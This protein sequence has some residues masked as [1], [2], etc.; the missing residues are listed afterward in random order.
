MK[1][2]AAAMAGMAVVD[3]SRKVQSANTPSLDFYGPAG[4]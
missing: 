3:L 1:S 2:Q 4:P